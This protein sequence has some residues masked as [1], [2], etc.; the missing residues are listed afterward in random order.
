M[1]IELTA[2]KTILTGNPAEKM[3]K[4]TTENIAVNIQFSCQ[5]PA[6]SFTVIRFKSK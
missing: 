1:Y 5:A 4:P 2:V 6:Y 3:A